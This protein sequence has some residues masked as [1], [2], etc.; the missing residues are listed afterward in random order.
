MS[1]G[2]VIAALV[3]LAGFSAQARAATYQCIRPDKTVVGA[4]T[5]DS[6]D[7]DVVCN[8]NYKS[9]NLVCTA[10]EHIVK[11]G[12]EAVWGTTSPGGVTIPD[13]NPSNTAREVIEKGLAQ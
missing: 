1:A 5:T 2:A 3:L 8:H 6:S 11:E 12:K 4:V 13:E 9:C 7:P 10:V